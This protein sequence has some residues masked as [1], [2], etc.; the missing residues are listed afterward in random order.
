MPTFA[1]LAVMNEIS[2]I[3][4]QRGEPL[5]DWDHKDKVVRQFSSIGGK[6]YVLATKENTEAETNG[7]KQGSEESSG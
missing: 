3:L 7:K 1:L 4:Q 2:G 6:L 5:R